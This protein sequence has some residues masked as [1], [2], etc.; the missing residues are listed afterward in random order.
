[1]LIQQQQPRTMS[2]DRQI[3]SRLSLKPHNHSWSS[4]TPL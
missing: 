3:I 4:D 1:M 2:N